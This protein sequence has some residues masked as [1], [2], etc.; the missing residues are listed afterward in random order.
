MKGLSTNVGMNYIGVCL[1]AMSI[2]ETLE[3]DWKQYLASGALAVM[4]LMAFLTRG[5]GLEPYEGPAL[6]DEVLDPADED[7][8]EALRRGREE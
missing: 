3:G 6:K 4:A 1:I 8:H 5:S 7:I 2:A